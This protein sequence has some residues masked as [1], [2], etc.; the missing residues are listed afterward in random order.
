MCSPWLRLHLT[1]EYPQSLPCSLCNP[2]Q[3]LA[4]CAHPLRV[5]ARFN[6]RLTP[7]RSLHLSVQ[8]AVVLRCPEG[9][10]VEAPDHAAAL[11]AEGVSYRATEFLSSMPTPQDHLHSHQGSNSL[12]IRLLSSRCCPQYRPC[13]QYCLDVG[14][15]SAL[16]E[17]V[18]S[19]YTKQKSGDCPPLLLNPVVNP[20]RA[21]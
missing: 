13:L 10:A 5:H 6:P 21:S 7:L 18:H 12:S 3:A 15:L 17:Q 11:E 9:G 2:S 14:S 1:S 4:P 20:C 19:V 16:H 8:A